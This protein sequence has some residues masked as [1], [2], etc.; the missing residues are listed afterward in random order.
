MLEMLPRAVD[1]IG[2]QRTTGA[3]LLPLGTNMK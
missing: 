2:E 1:L 3:S